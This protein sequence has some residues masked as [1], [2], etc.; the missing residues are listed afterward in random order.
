MSAPLSA[1]FSSS[2]RLGR[3]AEAGLRVRA[4]AEAVRQVAADV[5]LDVRLGCLQRL[6]VGVGRDEL[7]AAQADID[8]AADRVG[9]GATHADDLDDRE[10]VTAVHGNE[11]LD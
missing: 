3:G 2:A 5:D 9:P 1:S 4:G 10:V 11:S 7:D 6:G 8:H